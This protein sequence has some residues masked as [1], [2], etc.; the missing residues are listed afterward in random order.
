MANQLV[1]WIGILTWPSPAHSKDGVP[2]VET[3]LLENILDTADTCVVKE[4]RCS[5]YASGTRLVL[6]PLA[7]LLELGD[8]AYQTTDINIV[9]YMA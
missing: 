5:T 7:C 3:N 4:N 6:L 8:C 1:I 9:R 2:Y